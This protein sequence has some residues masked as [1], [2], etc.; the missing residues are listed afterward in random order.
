MSQSVVQKQPF[1]STT[2][3]MR[4]N[5]PL[6]NVRR[7]QH[8]KVEA[9]AKNNRKQFNVPVILQHKFA[10]FS[11]RKAQMRPHFSELSQNWWSQQFFMQHRAN[12]LQAN[13]EKIQFENFVFEPP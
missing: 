9:S 4:L 5:S 10:K 12:C 8:Q 7:F 13:P 11:K 3:C 2:I 1:P 6:H